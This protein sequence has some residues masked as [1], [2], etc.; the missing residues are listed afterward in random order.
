MNWLKPYLRA[1]VS[2]ACR[3]L[4]EHV[5]FVDEDAFRLPCG[6]WRVRELTLF[7]E[8]GLMADRSKEHRLREL[9]AAYVALAQR[10]KN[11]PTGFLAA[12]IITL[13]RWLGTH[14]PS[15]CAAVGRP[16]AALVPR[17]RDRP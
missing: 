2:D 11:P 1:D 12:V 5:D 9:V 13:R 4:A 15:H 7:I 17:G 14:G 3:V 10:K 16:P 8:A 6:A